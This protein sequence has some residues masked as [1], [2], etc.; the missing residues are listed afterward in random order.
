[1]CLWRWPLCCGWGC[2][3]PRA[4]KSMG[5]AATGLRPAHGYRFPR[6]GRWWTHGLPP[7]SSPRQGQEG[8]SDI[9]ACERSPGSSSRPGVLAALQSPS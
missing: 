2:W 9:A 7:Q 1:M 4:F 6:A 5:R 3:W 8:V